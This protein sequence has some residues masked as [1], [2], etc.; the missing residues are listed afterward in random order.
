[1]TVSSI[2]LSL[3][4][5]VVK[6]FMSSGTVCAGRQALSTGKLKDILQAAGP[7]EGISSPTFYLRAQPP[8]GEIEIRASGK[9]VADA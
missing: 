2:V 5:A 9:Y 4:M 8:H 1:M 6:G 3:S 7:S